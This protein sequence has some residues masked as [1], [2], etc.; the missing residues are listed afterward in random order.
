MKPILWMF[1]TNLRKPDIA[2]VIPSVAWIAE[3]NGAAFECYTECKRDGML[4]AETGSTVIGGHHFQSFNYLNC[5]FDVKYILYGETSVFNSS[6]R[7]FGN[8]IL[9]ETD[10]AETLY[11]TLLG[12]DFDSCPQWKL[13]DCKQNGKL[14]SPYLYP[15]IYFD[16]KLGFYDPDAPDTLTETDDTFASFTMRIANRFV[17]QAKGVAFGDPYAILSMLPLLCRE[18]RIAVYGETEP[19]PECKVQFSGYTE[20]KSRLYREIAALTEKT[21]NR[22]LVGRQTGDGDLFEWAK[23]GVCL[24]IMDPNRPA[25][26]IVKTIPHPWSMDADHHTIYDAEPDDDT[27]NRYADEGKILATVMVHSGEMAHNEAMIHLMDLI[28]ST[29][30]HFGFG[31]HAARYETCPQFWELLHTKVEAGGCR[32][33]AE[34][35]LH[36]GGLG[37]MAEINCP[38]DALYS[39]VTTAMDK[40]RAITTEAAPRGYYAFCDTDLDTLQTVPAPLYDKL[41]DAGLE[42]VVSSAKPGKNK[43]LYEHDGLAVLNQT[44]RAQCGTSPFVRI[45]TVQDVHEHAILSS[46]GW[47]IGTIDAPVVSFSPYIWNQGSEF[48]KIV[49]FITQTPYIVSA[50]PHTISRY[51]KLLRKRSEQNG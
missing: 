2:Y 6:I 46:P 31:V 27:L 41:A 12:A 50:T 1:I 19:L 30:M 49:R 21:G 33:F 37:V 9:C 3:Q 35:V 42:Y 39:Q 14:F 13:G 16:R 11:R 20:R 23:Y 34:P 4:F 32:G 5:V 17:S 51:A 8:E 24:Q 29:G 26:P 36:S 45:C 15:L 43:I 38:P 28:H 22:V 10:D 7:V 48:M 18:K 47:L 44:C 40:I 25:F